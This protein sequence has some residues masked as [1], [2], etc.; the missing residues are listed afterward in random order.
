M[1]RAAAVI[2]L[3]EAT[4][5]LLSRQHA[6]DVARTIVVP[7]GR[8]PQ[9]QAMPKDQARARVQEMFGL[10]EP[11]LLCVSDTRP[12][13]N[14]L[15]LVDAFALMRRRGVRHH[16]I[17]IGEL[18]QPHA[19]QVRERVLALGLSDVVHFL[20]K[21]RYESLPAVYNASDLF[22]FPSLCEACP[23]TV[24]EAMGC[25]L[26]LAVSDIPV[27]RE[28][29]ADAVAYFDPLDAK[30]IAEV[31]ENLLAADQRREELGARASQR[32][33]N[34]SWRRT[35]EHILGL[36]RRAAR[37]QRLEAQQSESSL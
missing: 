29:C 27:L 23:I 21:V 32:A 16:L 37:V 13:K 35:A 8:D 15:R 1:R 28:L 2:L 26:P 11:F 25:R 7:N 22:V 34:F 6:V 17:V 10:R 19:N 9:F 3:A 12:Y 24:I 5:A 30:A 20:Q 36:L 18:C 33:Q 4:R 31:C 14:Y